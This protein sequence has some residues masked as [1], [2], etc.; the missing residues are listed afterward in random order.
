[1][2]KRLL[3]RVFHLMEQA[4]EYNRDQQVDLERIRYLFANVKFGFLG[5][6]T[7]FA[8]LYIIAAYSISMTYANAWLLGALLVNLPRVFVTS[9][10]ERSQKDGTLTPESALAWE[11]RITWAFVP[12][13]LWGISALFLPYGDYTQIA[14]LLCAMV[15]LL[16]AVGG[17]LM[18][19]TSLPSIIIFL[20]LV[21]FSIALRLLFL[22][23]IL[24]KLAAVVMVVGYPQLIR[25]IQ[26]QNR[27]L[28]QNITLKIE[29][30][31]FALVDPLTRL[32]NRRQLQV[33]IDRLMPTAERSGE[34]FSLVMLDLD[35]FKD[36]NDSHGH[37][38]GD[39]LLVSMAGLMLECSRQ[40]DLVVRY[41]GEEFLL[42][43]P[44]TSVD[45]ARV[46]VERI[47]KATRDSTD[48]TISAGITQYSQGEGFDQVIQRADAALYSA[49][50][51]GR[52][53]YVIS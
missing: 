31:Q 33:V 22:E 14:V 42:V 50:E 53:Q 25:L 29:N 7:G 23:G 43:L 36:Y 15:Y 24:F 18:L 47:L 11:R 51:N 45:D 39:E 19:S 28:I 16:Q 13:Y 30:S 48:V 49:K 26:R 5:V 2:C 34:P 40:Q 3:D 46:I 1:M 35:R 6:I 21:C 8:T 10:Y 52:D 20:T 9:G 37:S 4:A 38:A 41:G 27:L 32:A 17:V 12:A 44:R